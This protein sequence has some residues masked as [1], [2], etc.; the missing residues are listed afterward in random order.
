MMHD[1]R[2][3]RHVFTIRKFYAMWII[4]EWPSKREKNNII[5]GRAEKESQK[6]RDLL[7][8][9][10]VY[11]YLSAPHLLQ[12]CIVVQF[13]NSLITSM[14]HTAFCESVHVL[15]QNKKNKSVLYYYCYTLLLLP[16]PPHS[17]LDFVG[18]F[19]GENTGY[20]G[21]LWDT[22]NSKSRIKLCLTDYYKPFENLMQI[23]QIMTGGGS[24]A[25]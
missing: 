15:L 19:Y 9:H 1:D 14:Y 16:L 5:K 21:L 2:R 6:R 4:I 25:G 23:Y 7:S 13:Y 22:I 3:Q 12:C 24:G 11:I 17:M 10:L 18:K 20:R 8:T